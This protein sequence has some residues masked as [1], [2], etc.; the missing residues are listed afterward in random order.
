MFSEDVTSKSAAANDLLF[1]GAVRNPDG[2]LELK[3]SLGLALSW[4]FSNVPCWVL[5]C[6][7][8]DLF[9]DFWRFTSTLI[10]G[11][12][13]SCL[14]FSVTP[15]V[16]SKA[17]EGIK[18]LVKPTVS[19]GLHSVWLPLFAHWGAFRSSQNLSA[20]DSFYENGSNNSHLIRFLFSY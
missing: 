8:M 5:S 20:S 1:Q 11:Y 12:L 15:S 19:T 4:Y 7:L 16:F 6:A 2:V 3:H 10:I 17:A 9:L 13:F 14:L 18:Y